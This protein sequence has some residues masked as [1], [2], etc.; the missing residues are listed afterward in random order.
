MNKKT[1]TIDYSLVIRHLNHGKHSAISRAELCVL[2]GFSDRQNRRLIAAAAADGHL[3]VSG[4]RGKGGYYLAQTTQDL[5]III[6]ECMSR[7]IKLIHRAKPAL[8]ARGKNPRQAF[9][10]EVMKNT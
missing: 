10:S 8:I 2:T 3:V 7:A 5:D 4:S 1:K 9:I 6:G